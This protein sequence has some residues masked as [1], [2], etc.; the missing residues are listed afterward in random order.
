MLKYDDDNVKDKWS[1]SIKFCKMINET[2]QKK[3]LFLP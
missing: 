2:K 3:Y 1:R